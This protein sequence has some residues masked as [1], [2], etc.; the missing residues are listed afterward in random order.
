MKANPSAS[1]ALRWKILRS[2]VG[3]D[4]LVHILRGFVLRLPPAARL[5]FRAPPRGTRSRYSPARRAGSFTC[6]SATASAS[7]LFALSVA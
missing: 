7:A 3:R 2:H 6:N 4:G 5:R 1:A